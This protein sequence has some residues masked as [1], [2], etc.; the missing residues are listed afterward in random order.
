MEAALI[1]LYIALVTF[2]WLVQSGLFGIAWRKFKGLPATAEIHVTTYAALTASF[3][4]A[5][6]IVIWAWDWR[7]IA[8]WPAAFV[9]MSIGYFRKSM[10]LEKPGD[11]ERMILW[12]F[13][14]CLI[15]LVGTLQ[16]KGLFLSPLGALAGPI[17]ALNKKYP[18]AL[19]IDWTQRSEAM[20]GA[21]LGCAIVL[22][23]ATGASP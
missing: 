10:G 5:V 18:T 1:A 20:Y 19:G 2:S 12:G 3:L 11:F 14:V 9:A 6:P 7:L 13:V 17:Y 8:L 23:F 21:V 4:I 15:V 22:S 16:V